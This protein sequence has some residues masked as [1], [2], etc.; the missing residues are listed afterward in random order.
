VSF[1]GQTLG[2]SLFGIRSSIRYNRTVPDARHRPPRPPRAEPREIAELRDIKQ[3]SPDLASAVDL[4]IAL[5]ELQHRLR[6]RLP[7]PWI[8][9]DAEWL[10][11][12]QQMG[13]PLLRF[14]DIPLAWTDFR[15]MCR[16]TAD[17]LVRYEALEPADH[18][19]LQAILR[20]GRAIEP[21]AI[22][23]YNAKAA[24]ERLN[25]PL[26]SEDEAALRAAGP[27]TPVSD[28]G[29]EQVLVLAMRPFLERCSE[30]LQQRTDFSNW[31]QP[32][33]PLCGGEPEFALINHAAD[34]LLICSR[35]TTR[36]RYHPLACPYCRNDDR[37]EITSFASRD[38]KYRL[39]ACNVCRRYL[40]A[41]DGRHAS[42]PVL[43][44][45]DS[46]A[47]LPLDAAAVQRG[48]RG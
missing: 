4:Q 35:C 40:K 18:A 28:D 11:R 16:Q 26:S 30:V 2:H 22:R 3:N 24:P 38:G 6:S 13:K 48:Y 42:R 27:L 23:W 46:I 14:E 43:L 34:R 9:A 45:V 36:W 17:I 1:A 37:A 5:L 32:Y 7:T 33:C 29:L 39:Y 31:S 15:L 12:Q 41:Y 19:A 8:E 21:L 47:T 25:E 20:T 44:A 10:K